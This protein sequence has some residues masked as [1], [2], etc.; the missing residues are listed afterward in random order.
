MHFDNMIIS[1]DKILHAEHLYLDPES[2]E[3]VLIGYP[4]KL[5][6]LERMIVELLIRSYP[7][8]LSVER[9]CD[10]V[11]VSRDSLAVHICTINKKAARI[12]ERRLILFS[13]GYCLNEFM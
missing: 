2:G 1:Y 12:S 3:A 13:N 9:L 11:C 8:P 4:L 7:E 5:S 6:K 10:E